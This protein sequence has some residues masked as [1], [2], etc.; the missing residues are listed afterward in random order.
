MLNALAYLAFL[1]AS[2]EWRRRLFHPKRDARNARETLRYYLRLR[3]DA[4]EQGLYNGLQRFAYTGALA[5]GLVQVL[6]GL[7]IYKPTQ[8]WWLAATFGGYDLARAVHLYALAALALFTLG[9]VL[10]V[11]LHPR[12]LKEMVTGGRR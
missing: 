5:L 1:F 2:G 4:P 10:M 9:H 3:R 11:A 6:S 12:T 8:L 7:A